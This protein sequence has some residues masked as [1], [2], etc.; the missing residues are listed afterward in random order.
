LREEGRSYS[1]S[2][3]KRPLCLRKP[4]WGMKASPRAEHS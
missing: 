2:W 3:W 4:N 1:W